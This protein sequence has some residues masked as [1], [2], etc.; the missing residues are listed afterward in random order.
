MSQTT[1]ANDR[2]P[3]LGKAAGF[4]SKRLILFAHCA[5][6]QDS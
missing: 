1:S 4:L 6:Y 5:L 2:I 3:V